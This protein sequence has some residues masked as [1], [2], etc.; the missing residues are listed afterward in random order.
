MC[1]LA[2]TLPR[3]IGQFLDSEARLKRGRFREESITDMITASLAVFAGPNLVI[4]YPVE[5]ETGSDLDLKFWNVSSGRSLCVRIQ[6]KRLNAA[7]KVKRIT[8]R[9]YTEL[10]HK[11]PTAAEYQYQV[12]NKSPEPWI[13]LYMFY[14]HKS[15]ADDT[16][17]AGPGPKVRGV[18]LAFAADISME[19]DEMLKSE[20]KVS[21]KRLSHL[22]Q[23]L[24]GVGALLCPPGDFKGEVV[25]SP[26][27]VSDAL[28]QI[29]YAKQKYP[30]SI[31][32]TD[33][34]AD[35][36]GKRVVRALTVAD[37]EARYGYAPR[38]ADGP[39]IRRA[40]RVARVSI[41]FISGRTEDERT[42][43][44]FDETDRVER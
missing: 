17:Y 25:P 22:R 19:I 37:L 5:A 26:E 41:T 9:S 28:R 31:V 42:P 24:F 10:D 43:K 36:E 1:N 38:L 3:L 29:F 11:T 4:E 23:H 32:D 15:V 12:L 44:I 18:N 33:E 35:K 16:Y 34:G 8:S 2:N 13:P 14:N 7:G 21:H 27:L 6:A 30:D 20:K 39:S 40:E